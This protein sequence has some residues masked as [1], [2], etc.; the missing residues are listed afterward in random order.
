MNELPQEIKTKLAR[1]AVFGE[2]MPRG[3]LALKLRELASKI[4]ILPYNSGNI[5]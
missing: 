1:L 3:E 4:E 5:S 2:T